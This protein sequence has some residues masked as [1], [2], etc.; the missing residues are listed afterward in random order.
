MTFMPFRLV[1]LTFD[2]NEVIFE[3]CKIC[4]NPE[5]ENLACFAIIFDKK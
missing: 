3:I 2:F 4:F 1:S 5:H